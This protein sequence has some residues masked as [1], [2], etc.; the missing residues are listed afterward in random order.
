ML[1]IS[2]TPDSLHCL[3]KSSILVL[4]ACLSVHGQSSQEPLKE[5][6]NVKRSDFPDDFVFG[7]STA[8]AQIEGSAKSGGKGPSAWDQFIREFPDKIM[9]RS[10]LDVAADSYNRYMEDVSNLKDLGVDSYRFSISWTRILPDGTLSGGINQEGI[11]HY[12]GF[13]DELIKNGIKP[14]VTLMHFD[15]PEALENKYGGFLNHSIVNDF[16]DYA[17]I[18]FKTFGDRVKNWITINEPLI[19]AKM[20]HALGTGPP[21]RCS[22]R[23]IC[24]T[25]NAATEPYIVSHNLLLAH[26]T[27]ANLY[28][29]M[30]Q[31]TQGGQIGISLVAQYFEPYSNTSLDIEAAKRSIDFE[32]GWFME[33]LVRGEYPESMRR[34]VK[35]RLPVFTAEEKEL[36]KGSFDFIG[37]NYYSSRYAKDIPPTPNVA[38]ISYLVDPNVNVTVD[39]DGVLIG[40]NAGGSVFIYV[41]PEGLYKIL[42]FMEENYSKNLT[43]YI[44]ENGYTEKSDDNIPISQTLKDDVRIEFIQKHLHQLQNAIKNG[45][46]VKGYFYYS[47]IDSFEWGEGYTVRY[48]LYR[49]DFKSLTRSPKD[50]AKWYHDFIKGV[51]K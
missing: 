9:D 5:Y 35:E 41:Y 27:A 33:P 21:G 30:Y 14:F 26:A 49:V 4:I 10:N 32:L 34:L 3:V 28:K 15:Q 17:E 37:V 38:P 13:I 48:G 19:M 24:P 51:P 18:C 50:S 23:K 45:V 44:T 12:N 11:D 46:N 40:P 31:A 47:L 36:V 2:T 22:D 25:G 16:K 1:S 8:A 7:A 29:H 42:K 39:K 43:I 6:V 20:G